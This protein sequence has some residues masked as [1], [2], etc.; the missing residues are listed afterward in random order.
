VAR[1][2]QDYYSL[3]DL[4][5]GASAL[6]VERAYRRAARA[7][8]PDTNPHDSSAAERFNAVTIAYQTLR[9]PGRRASYDR[10]RGPIRPVD[11]RPIVQRRPPTV[12]VAP[13]RVGRR[14]HVEPL[15]PLR[16]HQV[17]SAEPATVHL[18]E[19]VT[20]LSRLLDSWPL[21]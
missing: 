7:T 9:D 2:E 19:V 10:T 11:R 8:H 3:L 12:G 21:P 20:A 4:S 15:R 16:A 1:P 17:I 6:E 13:V 14:R 18:L 5:R